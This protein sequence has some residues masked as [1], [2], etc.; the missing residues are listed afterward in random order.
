V[1]DINGVRMVICVIYMY[2]FSSIKLGT[3]SYMFHTLH[4]YVGR[5]LF[6]GSANIE[7]YSRM[8]MDGSC[9]IQQEPIIWSV[10]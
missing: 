5:T 2:S 1:L 7:R 3:V 9:V 8:A 6:K 4:L 10:V